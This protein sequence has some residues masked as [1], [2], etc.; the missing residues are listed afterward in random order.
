VY[1]DG[2]TPEELVG[3]ISCLYGLPG[4]EDSAV[5]IVL[6]VAPVNPEVRPDIISDLLAQNLNIGQTLDAKGLTY[7]IWGDD[8]VQSANHNEI[9]ADAW[10]SALAQPGGRPAYEQAVA[11]VGAMRKSTTQ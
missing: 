10:Y 6:S 7:W 11:L 3:G 8:L 9:Y 5:S 2:P 4:E 1:F